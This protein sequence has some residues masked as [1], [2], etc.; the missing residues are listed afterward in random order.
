MQILLS[1]AKDMTDVSPQGAPATSKPLFQRQA[2]QT[3]AY[4][5]K[6]SADDLAQ[7]LKT[8]SQ[9]AAL[10]KLRYTRFLEPSPTLP[11]VLAYTGIAYKYLKAEEMTNEQMTYAD[12][13]L[14][15]TSFLYGLLR[16]FNGIKNYRLE[17]TVRLP[18]NDDKRMFD[19]W[20]PLLTDVLINSVKQDD[21]ILLN[22]ASSEMKHLFNWK[23]VA[24]EI[25][26]IEPEF[27]VR[28]GDRLKT[29]VVYT[30]MCRGAM[31]RHA[32]TT[33]ASTIDTLKAFEFEG[34]AY[35]EPESDGDKL[36]YTM[37]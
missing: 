33:Q 13:H 10:N 29:I 2:E 24:K 26:I 11:A 9:L 12:S 22:L 7:M 37:E 1:C 4:M 27:M 20:K 8:N 32:I 35:N 6:Y 17:G 18:E 36:V 34:F 3:A 21:G 30:K 31:T 5:M 28:K 25:R 15:I 19:Y 14:W 23:R 16:P